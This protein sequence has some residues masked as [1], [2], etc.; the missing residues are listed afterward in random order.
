MNEDQWIYGIWHVEVGFG[1]Y[2]AKLMRDGQGLYLEARTRVYVD[3]KVHDSEDRKKFWT[4]RSDGDT[5]EQMVAKADLIAE[6][7][8]EK[9]GSTVEFVLLECQMSDPKVF[10]ELGQKPWAHIKIKEP[11]P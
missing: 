1:N 6:K 9:Y 10:F 5:L 8:A 2:M 11:N 3:D 4:A 7:V